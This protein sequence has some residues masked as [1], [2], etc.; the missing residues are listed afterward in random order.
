MDKHH[1]RIAWL[2]IGFGVFNGLMALYIL[3]KLSDMNNLHFG[4]SSFSSMFN[5]IIFLAAIIP[6]L[7]IVGGVLH[8]LKD[9]SSIPILSV[10]SV[11][12]LFT[13]PI[14]THRLQLLCIIFGI[15]CFS[16]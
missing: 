15:S 6:F 7:S 4:D 16:I 13:F 8:Y 14:G 2:F 5:A 9:G 11:L 12:L 1:F 3:P 10:V